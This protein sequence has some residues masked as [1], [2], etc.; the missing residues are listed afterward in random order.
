[1]T[2]N[3]RMNTLPTLPDGAPTNGNTAE[4][5]APKHTMPSSLEK[6]IVPMR[7]KRKTHLDLTAASVAA[8]MNNPQKNRSLRA[9]PSSLREA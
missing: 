6:M 3:M 1:M 2:Y 9:L 5:A 7:G 4:S 8:L